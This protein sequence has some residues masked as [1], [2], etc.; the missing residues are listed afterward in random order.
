MTHPCTTGGDGGTRDREWMWEIKHEEREG[1]ER[2]GGNRGQ[3][4]MRKPEKMTEEIHWW[5]SVL[6]QGEKKIHIPWSFVPSQK[7]KKKVRYSWHY[8]GLSF[9]A[10]Y[11]VYLF[12]SK[13]LLNWKIGTSL[14]HWWM[15]KH[16]P[17]NRKLKIKKLL[18]S[19]GVW[20]S[21]WP[22]GGRWLIFMSL[23][24]PAY[25][26]QSQPP[27]RKG[28]GQGWCGKREIVQRG[29]EGAGREEWAAVILKGCEQVTT[30][31]APQLQ[32]RN[33][34]TLVTVSR[35]WN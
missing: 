14:A 23:S 16:R 10:A 30:P 19:W 24:T 18:S 28:V 25:I 22:E 3:T 32:S 27:S 17:M 15:H 1:T 12:M 7:K 20:L 8:V 33:S 29:R 26:N 4:E 31:S 13:F 11:G 34:G 35:G 2:D 5:F 21:Q 9:I 6:V